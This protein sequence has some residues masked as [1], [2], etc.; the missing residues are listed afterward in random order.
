MES[1]H[2]I[3]DQHPLRMFFAILTEKNFYEQLG[4]VDHGVIRYVADLLADF[5]DADRVYRFHDRDGRRCTLV[6]EMLRDAEMG[7]SGV[8]EREVH[9][10]IGDFTL[11][12]MGLFP[13]HLARLKTRILVSGGDFLLDYVKV[14]KRSYRIVSELPEAAGE[15]GPE[16]APLFR[17]LSD[18]FE[19]CVAG[20][21]CIREDLRRE[22]DTPWDRFRERF[23]N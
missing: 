8:P 6:S 1:T 22:P 23:L 17:K 15:D 10:Q 11:F 2:R 13:E 12:M 19:L 7:S 3:S 16:E 14:G 9:R 18:H 21:G 20:L 4:W 5:S